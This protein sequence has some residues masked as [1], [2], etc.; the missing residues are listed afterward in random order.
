MTMDILNR[1]SIVIRIPAELQADLAELQ[2]Q[3]RRRAGAD[4]VRWTPS[5]ELVLT[6]LSLGEIGVGQ[7]AQIAATL[8]TIASRHRALD[9]QLE[10]LGGSPNNL[11]PRLLWVGVGGD[12]LGLAQLQQAIEHAVA[13]LV[14]HQ[15]LR[16]FQAQ[17]PIGR[18]KQ[19]SE[20]NRSALGR[21]VR[22]AQI[23]SVGAFT[24]PAVEL[25]RM[26]ATSAG[27]TIVTVESFAL[28]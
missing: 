20:A 16:Q 18:L 3:I 11:Q 7:M 26:A 12:V 19:E 25:I 15:E 17:V 1:C 9:L 4:L 24:A 5:N 27:P 14:P 21:A 23:G 13:P 8:P 10:G 6:L 2:L 28:T 22:M